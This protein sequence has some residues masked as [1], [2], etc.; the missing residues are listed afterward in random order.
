MTQ[1]PPEMPQEL[2]VKNDQVYVSCDYDDHFYIADKTSFVPEDESRYILAAPK[3]DVERALDG[4]PEGRNHGDL[5][6]WIDNHGE[7][8]RRVLLANVG[9]GI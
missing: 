3:E 6:R 9:R 5:I 2:F 1:K 7:T 4:M 8:I